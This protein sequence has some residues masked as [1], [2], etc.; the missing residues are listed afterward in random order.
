MYILIGWRDSNKIGQ[1]AEPEVV[2]V[3]DTRV[4]AEREQRLKAAEYSSFNLQEIAI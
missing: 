4:D 2:G 1:Y 3:Y